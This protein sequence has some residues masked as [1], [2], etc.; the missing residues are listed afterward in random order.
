MA[1]GQLSDTDQEAPAVQQCMSGVHVTSVEVTCTE[2]TVLVTGSTGTQRPCRA[3]LSAQRAGAHGPRDPERPAPRQA[4]QAVA[5]LRR[6]AW[7]P[8]PAA[9]RSLKDL[10]R[11][12]PPEGPSYFANL[13]SCE[14][15]NGSLAWHMLVFI[16]VL[17]L[18]M[19]VFILRPTKSE[20]TDF[21][22]SQ[23]VIFLYKSK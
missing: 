7:L 23:N 13:S 12:G 21:G 6:A 8:R 22:R 11:A 5:P 10:C 17:H 3:R 1:S 18:D 9:Y 4:C 15:V 14:P 2:S 16:T 20:F 19:S